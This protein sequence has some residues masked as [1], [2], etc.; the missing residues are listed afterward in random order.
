[1]PSFNYS[2]VSGESS[3]DASL[4]DPDTHQKPLQPGAWSRTS[5][6]VRSSRWPCILV[7]LLLILL[8]E[9]SII[10]RQ[11]A[12]VQLGGELNSL[13]PDFSKQQ[14][15]F[16]EDHRFNSDHKTSESVNTTKQHWLDL[17]PHG[18]G[19]VHVPDHMSYTLPPPMHYP[20]TPGQEVYAIALFHE[21]HCLMSISG[22]M[23][24]LVLK[25][26]QRDFT[27]SEGEVDHNDHCFSY[28]RNA[29]MCCGDTTLEGQSQTPMFKNT[30]GT[31]GTGAVH[32]CRNYDEIFAWASQHKLDFSGKGK[33]LEDHHH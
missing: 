12:S 7:L 23:D 31:D 1:M 29:I 17:M 9:L 15:I 2:K 16:R 18:D 32:I 14:K 22:F 10:N 8:G 19:F 25:I 26:R 13:L 6:I 24:K 11:P 28:L 27:L 20:E 3:G 21:L 4:V 30:P 33:G 5:K